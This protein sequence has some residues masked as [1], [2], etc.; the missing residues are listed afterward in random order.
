[1]KEGRQI[2]HWVFNLAA[3]PAK[4]WPYVSDTNR[5]F[6]ILGAPPV[7]EMPLS[8]NTPKGYLELSHS[9]LNS[10]VT[11]QEEPYAWETPF[12]FKVTRNYKIGFL[13]H[14]SILT[15]CIE[16]DEGTNLIVKVTVDPSNSLLYYPIKLYVNYVLKKK[17]TGYLEIVDN[18]VSQGLHPYELNEEKSLIRGADRKIERIS[19]ELVEKTKRKRIVRHLIEL[20]RKAE[21]EDLES[22]HPYSLAEYWGEKK[23]SVLN[24][25]LHA[26]N[27]DL[28]DFSWDICCPRCKSPKNN[29]RKLQD[30]RGHLYCEDCN[31]DYTMDFNKNTH[32]VFKPHPLIRSISDKKYCLGGPG[33]KPHRVI[34][35]SLAIGDERYPELQLEE[36]TYL[37]RTHNHE[38]NLVFHVREDGTDN[39]NIYV[40]DEEFHSQS[41]TISKT[42]NLGIFNH[43]SQ[44][45]VCFF[46]KLNWKEEAI[47]A[48]E[49]CSNVDFNTLFPNETLKETSKV[50]ASEVT[51][52]FTDLMNS[53]ELYVK[54]GDETAI[55]RVMGHFRVIQQII[56]EER[57]GIVKTIGDSVMAVFWEPVSALKAVQRIQQI[58]SNSSAVGNA[59]KIKAGVHFGDCTAVN[60]NGRIDYFGTTVN[61]A[62]RLVD[63]ASE[64]EIMLSEALYEHPDIKLYL[65]KNSKSFFV[66]DSSKELKG[67]SE[68]E[69]KV[70]Q[71]RLERPPMRLV[72]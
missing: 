57:G 50:K 65:D 24:V 41:I 45:M 44:P 27:L 30:T 12:R 48:T 52:L 26:T 21:D 6:R 39:V 7:Q 59:F 20:I 8:R 46:D 3:P 42:P 9:I 43:S 34:Q 56:A 13:E 35:Q 70:K 55:G 49:V 66:K 60:L 72:I 47:Y 28:L 63:A 68:E 62:S 37:F 29:F 64:K 40:T 4:L 23:Y 22:I 19:K 10:Q 36:G 61:L 51:M 14:M 71:I 18:A 54:E 17:L 33:N 58:F 31:D 25:F 32:L 15:E 16:T 1:M 11:W 2:H 38:G 5:I 69:I 53:T 67:F